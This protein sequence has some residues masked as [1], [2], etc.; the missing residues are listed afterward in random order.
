MPMDGADMKA[1]VLVDIM[2]S[3]FRKD[4]CLRFLLGKER[5]FF[6]TLGMFGIESSCNPWLCQQWWNKEL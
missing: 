5:L 2:V 3:L 4:Q 1:S 6:S